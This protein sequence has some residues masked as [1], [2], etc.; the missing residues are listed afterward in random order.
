[1]KNKQIE[2]ER[3]FVHTIKTIAQAYEEISVIKMQRV[4][5]S[6]LGARSFLSDLSTVFADVTGSYHDE[7]MLL[8]QKKHHASL[9]FRRHSESASNQADL[10][11][12]NGREVVVLVSANA[13]LYGDIINKVI[14]RFLFYLS[15]HKKETNVDIAIIGR[16][17]RDLF[18]QSEEKREYTYFEI[19][20]SGITLENLKSLAYFLEKYQKVTVFYGKFINVLTQDATNSDI[21]GEEGSLEHTDSRWQMTDGKKKIHYFFEPSLQTIFEFFETQVFSLLLKQTL[22]EAELS[23]IA[24]RLQAMENALVNIGK[25][26]KSLMIAERMAQKQIENKKRIET[27]SGLSLWGK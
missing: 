9:S 8:M 21:T 17:G 13:K 26:E 16:V 10:L 19:P 7:I 18:E 15:S 1:M 5:S 4:R 24:S 12:K 11:G 27:F 23:R 6:V 14:H 2:N 25:T 22:H 3:E 20:D